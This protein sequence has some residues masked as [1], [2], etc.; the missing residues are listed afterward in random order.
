MKYVIVGGSIAAAT[1]YKEI[2]KYA[3]DADVKVISKEKI[4]PYAKMLLPYLISSED[5]KKNMFFEV[6]SSDIL[7]NSAVISVDT[8]SKTIKTENGQ[9]FPYDKLLI[10]TGADA[11][12]PKYSGTYSQESVVGV[13]YLQ[14]IEK[15][16]N[17]LDMCKSKH[18]ILHGAG[19]VTLEVGWALV[20]RGFSITYVVHSNRILS[21][22]LDK[23]SADMVEGYIK[24]NYSVRFIKGDD[25]KSIDEKNDKVYVS[26]ES[27][28]S[29]EGCLVIVGK[30]VNPNIDFL[31]TTNIESS[32][33]GI[34]VNKYLQTTDSDVYA[35]GDVSAFDDV[36][37]NQKKIH[38]I[39]PVAVEQ[40][41]VAAKNML[42]M[43]IEYM[44]EFSRNLLP[45][46]GLNIFTGG[47]SN[48]NEFDVYKRKSDMEYRKIILKDGVLKGFILIG[49]IGNFGAY[50]QIARRQINVAKN[51]DK[52]LYGILNINYL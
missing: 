22:I 4:L 45:V 23:E 43:K 16:K 39:W 51:I 32:E 2:K 28:D 47:I 38:A 35:V 15:I 1:A 26:L 25:I 41:K 42:G 8:E 5:V 21:R 14:D 36:V 19:L 9:E 48:K 27:G 24:R 11:K 7:L 33:R 6:D 37:D 3:K 31:K 30:G 20:K 44:P 40:A 34:T 50:T 10:A 17:R 29:L 13:R 49:D 46:F 12:I 18:V 52:L